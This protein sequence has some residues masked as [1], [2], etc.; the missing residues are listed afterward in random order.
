MIS[1]AASHLLSPIL[2]AIVALALVHFA[3]HEKV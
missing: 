3:P 1:F 2:F